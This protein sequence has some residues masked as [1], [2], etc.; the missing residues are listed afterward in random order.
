VTSGKAQ[1]D[2]S[3]RGFENPIALLGKEFLGQAPYCGFILDQKNCLGDSR[4]LLRN[5]SRFRSSP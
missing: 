5:G 1:S 2:C 3:V 4:T